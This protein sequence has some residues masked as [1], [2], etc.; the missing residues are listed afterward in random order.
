MWI[1]YLCAFILCI[2]F[3][4]ALCGTIREIRALKTRRSALQ[5][6]TDWLRKELVQHLN[7]KLTV[8]LTL[9]ERRMILNALEAPGFK[10]RIRT[11]K[12]KKYIRILYNMAVSRMKKSIEGKDGQV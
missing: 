9:P 4:A 8:V 5:K 3:G 1:A 12:T 10:D 6:E 7:T 11:P 2:V